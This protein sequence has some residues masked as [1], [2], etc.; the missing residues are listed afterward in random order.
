MVTLGMVTFLRKREKAR[1]RLTKTEKGLKKVEPLLVDNPTYTG[2]LAAEKGTR[3]HQLLTSHI[4]LVPSQIRALLLLSHNH[5]LSSLQFYLGNYNYQI[6][7]PLLDS[8]N[9][10]G[11]VFHA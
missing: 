5:D 11:T 8:H 10:P 2:I 6:N 1:I 3:C 7:K 9:V 4:N